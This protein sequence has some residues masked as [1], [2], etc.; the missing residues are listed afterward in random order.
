MRVHSIYSSI[1]LIHG[2][3]NSIDIECQMYPRFIQPDSQCSKMQWQDLHLKW[4]I[5]VA[6]ERQR[7]II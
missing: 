3:V 7:Y 4:H 6:D 1:L 5:A 2:T